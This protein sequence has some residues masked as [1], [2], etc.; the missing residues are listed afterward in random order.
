MTARVRCWHLAT[1]GGDDA[2]LG[3][4]ADPACP[5][6]FNKDRWTFAGNSEAFDAVL[7][8]LASGFSLGGALLRVV[9]NSPPAGP[10]LLADGEQ[11]VAA[12]PTPGVRL[13]SL[14]GG[15]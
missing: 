6:P 7:A 1:L 2:G 14:G 5:A 9:D 8:Q 4:C 10:L 15:I 12:V 3:A 11:L 13:R